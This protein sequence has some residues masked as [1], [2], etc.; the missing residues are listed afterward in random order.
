MGAA[1]AR[2]LQAVG[3]LVA[4]RCLVVV[5][6]VMRAVGIGVRRFVAAGVATDGVGRHHETRIESTSRTTE[7]RGRALAGKLSGGARRVD[8]APDRRGEGLQT[9]PDARNRKDSGDDGSSL[10]D[11][12][13]RFRL[14]ASGGQRMDS[15]V[16][17]VGAREQKAQSKIVGAAGV[18][19]AGQ[20]ILSMRFGGS[21]LARARSRQPKPAEWVQRSASV[22]RS[23]RVSSGDSV[24]RSPDT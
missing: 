24:V 23:R 10:T 1:V 6:G 19:A 4:S 7:P 8:E 3:R 14:S 2:T 20:R 21:D 17:V 11:V 15:E 18:P 22:N 13:S 5:L 12:R 9:L 16:S